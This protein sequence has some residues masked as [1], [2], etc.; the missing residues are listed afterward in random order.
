MNFVQKKERDYRNIIGIVIVVCA[1]M[2]FVESVLLPAYVVKTAFKLVLFLGSVFFCSLMYDF[3]ILSKEYNPNALKLIIFLGICVYLF[4]LAG[5][6][7]IHDFLDVEQIRQSL[8][9]KEGIDGSNFIFVALYISIVNSFVEELLFRGLAFRE[10][11]QKG[12][13]FLAYVFSAGAFAIYHVGII[14]GWFSFPVFVLMVVGLFVAGIL[15]NFFCH[16]AD[17]IL[18]SWV[19]HATANLAINTIGFMIL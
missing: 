5:Y 1:A 9:G 15:L 16:Y 7:I 4:I 18:G 19:I 11:H 14:S 2:I 10:L 3:R 8:M 12:H 17:S 6:F 13:C